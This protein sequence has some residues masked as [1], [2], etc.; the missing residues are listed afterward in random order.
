MTTPSHTMDADT[1]IELLNLEQHPEG[2]YFRETY[3][4]P[5][6][7]AS[8]TTD[9]GFPAGRSYSTAI[10]FLLKGDQHSAFHR[11]RSDEI[12]H[13]HLGSAATIH[14]IHPDSLYEA[15][16]LGS[17]LENG[18][19]LQ[20]VVPAGSWFGVTVNHPESFSLSSCT[21]SP[22]FHFNDF[23]M[24]DPYRLKNAFPE[25]KEIIEKLS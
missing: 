3:R 25:H 11:I 8:S 15:L 24:A 19:Q 23:E 1:I 17:D 2:G 9:A 7:F 20:H 18:Q 16:Y 14:I 6:R 21:V 10:Y 4:S 22:G 5:H 13:Y 12:W